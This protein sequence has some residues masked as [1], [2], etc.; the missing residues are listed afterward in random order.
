VKYVTHG[1]TPVV[2]PYELADVHSIALMSDQ[3][4]RGV[5]G[6]LG[7][8]ISQAFGKNGLGV[9]MGE[10]GPKTDVGLDVTAKCHCDTPGV[11]KNLY[12]DE[13][14]LHRPN[15]THVSRDGTPVVPDQPIRILFHW[16]DR[17]DPAWKQVSQTCV[18]AQ[19]LSPACADEFEHA[20]LAFVDALASAITAAKRTQR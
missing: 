15:S 12:V 6:S 4:L 13:A 17:G 10:P 16:S 1:A 11:P 14:V 18:G 3:S 19:P 5:A 7:Q 2:L 8:R 20:D 9:P